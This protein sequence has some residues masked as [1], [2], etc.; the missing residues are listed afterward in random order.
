M[1]HDPAKIDELAIYCQVRNAG[2][3]RVRGKH[4][5]HTGTLAECLPDMPGRL[6]GIWGEFDATAMPYLAER[7]EKLNKF[8]P[9]ASFDI[10]PGVGHWTQYEAHER[11]NARVRE[12][13]K[14]GE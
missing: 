14:G 2:L 8:R 1:I 10:F 13:L 12:I 9:G 7:R 5:S 6:A 11:F 4:V 3:S